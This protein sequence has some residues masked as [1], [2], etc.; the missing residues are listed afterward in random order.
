MHKKLLWIPQYSNYNTSG[1]FILEADSNWQFV[2]TKLPMMFRENPK[3][4]VRVIVPWDCVTQPQDLLE[5]AFSNF[6]DY[7]VKLIR[8]GIVANAAQTRY[9]FDF[10]TWKYNVFRKNDLADY[11]HVYVNDPMLVRHVKTLFVIAK[12]VMPKF[13]THTHFLDTPDQPLVSKDLSYWHG[14]V[15]ACVK[16]DVVMWHC[17]AMQDQFID[18]ANKDYKH[19]IVNL[20]HNWIVGATSLLFLAD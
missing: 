19:H 11:T 16:S 12:K 7:D 18:A 8:V 13:I 2:V 14:T 4:S 9:D 15:E 20:G 5:D 17:N 1:K 6:R 10:E 3:M